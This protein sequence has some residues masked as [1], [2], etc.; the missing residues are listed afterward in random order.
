MRRRTISRAI[1][2]LLT[3]ALTLTAC[4]T[5]TKPAPHPR[6]SS[7][8][9]P[10]TALAAAANRLKADSFTMTMTVKIDT[11]DAVVVGAMDAAKKAGAFTV[12]TTRNGATS[13]NEWRILGGTVYRKSE[14]ASAPRNATRPWRRINQAD[15][16]ALAASF[17]GATMAGPLTRAT[18]V[19]RTSDTHF[20]G[21]LT[22][23]AVVDALSLPTPATSANTSLA[24]TVAFTADLDEQGR[25]IRYHLDIPRRNGT[26]YPLE[27]TYA[28]F[29]QDVS[30][31]PP[32]AD[33]IS[34]APGL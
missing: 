5:G 22:T 32:P 19:Q 28:K 31:Q 18:G 29:G 17:D 13:I 33:E 16:P 10:A 15:A 23:T 3:A 1:A 26:T 7:A 8:K 34:G 12:T 11:T 24:P 25:L 27:L 21:S 30:V 14:A 2:S 20:T 9:T 6:S 4:T